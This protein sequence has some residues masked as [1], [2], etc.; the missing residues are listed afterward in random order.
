MLIAAT[1]EAP[2]RGIMEKKREAFEQVREQAQCLLDK[3]REDYEK[4][5]ET[6]ALQYREHTNG[7]NDGK[8]E[9]RTNF[10]R[11]LMYVNKKPSCPPYSRMW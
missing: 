11:T 8:A 9:R 10:S 1:A 6:I 7:N 5:S 2:N 4:Q 3:R